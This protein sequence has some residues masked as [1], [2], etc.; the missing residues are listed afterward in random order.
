MSHE[1]KYEDWQ[2]KYKEIL[3]EYKMTK[4]R[5]NELQS[6]LQEKQERYIERE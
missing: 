3:S 2:T 4:E 5:T 6:E 1:M